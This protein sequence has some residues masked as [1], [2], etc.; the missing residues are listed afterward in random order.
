MKVNVL[1]GIVFILIYLKFKKKLP[2]FKILVNAEE[3]NGDIWQICVKGGQKTYYY[4]ISELDEI[5][6]KMKVKEN[7]KKIQM[8]KKMKKKKNLI[9]KMM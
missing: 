6:M 5:Q 3:E 4:G 7:M 8:K 2:K 9:M 1:N